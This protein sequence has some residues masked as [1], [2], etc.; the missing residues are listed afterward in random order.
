[1]PRAI[2]SGTVTFGL[3]NVP[4]KAFSASKDH[5]VHFNQLDK[6][7]GA[8]VRYEKVSEKSHKALD[9]DEI[10]LGYE[11]RK[12]EYVT[13]DRDELDAMQPES[14]RTLEVSDF[15]DLADIDP[16]YF[17]RTYWI[18]PDGDAAARVSR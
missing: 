18:A 9:S 10:E 11:I 14:T 4:V 5:S 2:W 12:G 6:K 13:F 1:M 7:S 16:I 3:V 15:V 17:E 8:R